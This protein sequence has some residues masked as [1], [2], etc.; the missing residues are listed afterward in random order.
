MPLLH[1]SDAD[2]RLPDGTILF[3]QLNL[4]LSPGINA[5]VGDNGCGK[6]TLLHLLSGHL[7][8]TTGTLKRQGTVCVLP[9]QEKPDAVSIASAIGLHKPYTAWLRLNQG[10]AEE[11][12]YTLLEDYWDVFDAVG[13]ALNVMGRS[14]LTVFDPPTSLSGGQLKQ[15]ALAVVFAREADFLLLDEPDN[16]LD[17]DGQADLQHKIHN[18]RSTVLLISHHPR[19]LRLAENII[20]LSGSPAQITVYGGHFDFYQAEKQ[21]N[22]EI[23][24][25]QFSALTAAHKKQQRFLQKQHDARQQHCARAQQSRTKG[26]MPKIALD[27]RRGQAES[28]QGKWQRQ[29]S[30][31]KESSLHK[32]LVAKKLAE[33]DDPVLFTLPESHVATGKLVYACEPI[34]LPHS[35]A[36]IP[37]QRLYGAFRLHICGKNGCGKSTLLRL[38]AETARVPVALI[39]QHTTTNR[40]E[41]L[42]QALLRADCPLHESEQRTRLSLL[43]LDTDCC[44]R[45]LSTLSGGEAVKAALALALWRRT[46]AQLLLLDEP[47]NHLDLNAVQSLV[48]C[49]RSF[50]GALA[51]VSHDADFVE[52]LGVSEQLYCAENQ[53]KWVKTI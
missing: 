44:T 37:E 40:Q 13:Q 1:L 14:D 20:E 4:I 11:A 2:Y 51:V 3:H 22:Q 35:G 36:T 53:W 9:Q 49:L 30:A 38:M 33:Q 12:D 18:T 25:K 46:P 8:P 41:S 42:L 39:E 47:D 10:D 6:S 45:P 16:H 29:Q 5:L 34:Y 31:A 17:A 21:K 23:R 43:G 24:D 52:Q 19:L 7:K 32:L 26:G 28:T 27:K 50:T 48:N 15:A